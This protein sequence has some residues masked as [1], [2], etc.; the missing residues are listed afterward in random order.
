MIIKTVNSLYFLRIKGIKR[1]IKR[2]WWSIKIL[3]TEKLAVNYL[4]VY[5]GKSDCIRSFFNV[6]DKEPFYD[7]NIMI[8]TNNRVR[9]KNYLGKLNVQIKGVEV[10]NAKPDNKVITY[11]VRIDDLKAYQKDSGC[12]YFVVHVDK[13][14]NHKTYYNILTPL[15]IKELLNNKN[16]ATKA[17]ELELVPDDIKTFE[18][19][20]KDGLRDCKTQ[21]KQRQSDI[22]NISDIN[23]YIKNDYRVFANIEPHMINNIAYIYD[24]P[25]TFYINKNTNIFSI[26][27]ITKILSISN[28]LPL[29]ISINGIEYYDHIYKTETK[30]FVE[31]KFGRAFTFKF[32]RDNREKNADFN[33]ALKVEKYLLSDYITDTKFLVELLENKEF[34]V[35][36]GKISDTITLNEES[37]K[38]FDLI[39]IKKYNEFAIEIDAILNILELNDDEEL[40]IDEIDNNSNNLLNVLVNSLLKNEAITYNAINEYNPFMTLPIGNLCLLVYVE[41]TDNE[42]NNKIEYRIHTVSEKRFDCYKLAEDGHTKEK[43]SHYYILTPDNFANISN[44]NQEDIVNSYIDCKN[45]NAVNDCIVKILGGYD[46]SKKSKL[47]DLAEKLIDWGLKEVNDNNLYNCLKLNLLQIKVRKNIILSYEEKEYLN[48]II[49]DANYDNYLKVGAA[50][51]L[52]NK[53]KVDEL[54]GLLSDVELK[55][56]KNMPIYNLYRENK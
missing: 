10:E 5:I 34:T 45:V 1:N 44:L 55:N 54:L 14:G 17:M 41:R 40:Y 25:H 39:S 6:N 36:C 19:L 46:K 51:I 27:G 32:N 31:C 13:N 37:L 33:I 30:D 38:Q 26:N 29:R 42:N 16:I 8:Y 48:T 22:I 49:Y 7:G 53:I 4:E 23:N 35:T 47:L 52:N 43:I 21:S 18:S 9:N 12:V 2:N 24:Y 28:N 50:I 11:Q 20:I 15:K 3:D 56:L